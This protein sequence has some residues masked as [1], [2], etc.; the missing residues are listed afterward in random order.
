MRTLANRLETFE[1]RI[2][3]ERLGGGIPLSWLFYGFLAWQVLPILAAAVGA[4]W[5]FRHTRTVLVVPPPPP[6]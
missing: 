3:A 4:T 1:R 6:A 2:S 5:L